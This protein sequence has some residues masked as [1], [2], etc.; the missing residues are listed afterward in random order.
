MFIIIIISIIVV[1]V[2]NVLVQLLQDAVSI[3]FPCVA[4]V[5]KL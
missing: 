1:I 4:E 5:E 2:Y 3:L